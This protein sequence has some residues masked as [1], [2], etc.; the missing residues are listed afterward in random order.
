MDKKYEI[1]IEMLKFDTNKYSAEK[2]FKD[3]ISL[4]AISLSNNVKFNKEN[5]DMYE[6][7]YQ[8]YEQN[9]RFNFYNLATEIS[10]IFYSE[11]EPYDV[12]GTIYSKIKKQN[13]LKLYSKVTPLQEVGRKLQGIVNINKKNNNGKMLEV[14]CG[15]G[16]MILA[17][18]SMLKTF[19][20]DYRK[21]LQV[22]A[23]DSD[24]TNVFMTYIQLYFFKIAAEVILINEKTNQEIM[25]LYTPNY[26]DEMESQMVA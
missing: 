25:R 1:F 11:T 14:N 26:E 22:T 17:Y 10:R 7:I 23:I 18:A 2:V 4:F 13:Y 9:K 21:N 8:S 6:K 5:C 15:T 20:I 19:K 12:L 3:F 24:L 16:A